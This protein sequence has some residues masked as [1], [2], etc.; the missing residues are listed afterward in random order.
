MALHCVKYA[1]RRVFTDPYFP[2]YDSVLKQEN[3]RKQKSVFSNILR[4]VNLFG[5]IVINNYI[6]IEIFC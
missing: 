6:T 4:R 3:M 5:F 1:R 2:I